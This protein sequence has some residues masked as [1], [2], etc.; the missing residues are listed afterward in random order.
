[1]G[2]GDFFEF[3]KQE[4]YTDK[5]IKKSESFENANYSLENLEVFI[6]GLRIQN[7]KLPQAV[8]QVRQIYGLAHTDDGRHSEHVLKYPPKV[9]SFSAGPKKVQFFDSPE[10]MNKIELK[11]IN[12]RTNG[13][14][15]AVEAEAVTAETRTRAQL[16]HLQS[17]PQLTTTYRSPSSLKK[18]NLSER[19]LLHH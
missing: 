9:T 19:L 13:G 10:T 8:T 17:G 5:E 14:A 11:L 7:V 3:L 4:K 6:Q 16:L 1:M 18:L 15:E 2:I 12:W